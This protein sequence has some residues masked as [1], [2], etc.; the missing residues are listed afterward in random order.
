MKCLKRIFGQR[1]YQ[2]PNFTVMDATAP[3][4]G[5][6]RINTHLLKIGQQVRAQKV[7][8]DFRE[9]HSGKIRAM[10]AEDHKLF[11]NWLDTLVANN[12]IIW[13]D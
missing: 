8:L 10:W 5:D 13:L 6:R 9:F 2:Y 3:Y 1:I 7:F 12:I 11:E 4:G